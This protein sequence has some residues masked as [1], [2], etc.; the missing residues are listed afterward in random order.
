MACAHE[1]Q[2]AVDGVIGQAVAL[3][4]P[5]T[6]ITLGAHPPLVAENP[7]GLRRGIAGDARR[8]GQLADRRHRGACV[9]HVRE[10]GQSGR[11]TEQVEASRP[12]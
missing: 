2:D 6:G 1:M 3:P 7:Q 4:P 10:Q 5:V 8:I 12:R 11:V 9:V